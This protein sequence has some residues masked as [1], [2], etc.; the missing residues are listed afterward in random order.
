MA[1]SGRGSGVVGYNVQAA[2]DTEHDLIVAHDITNDGS[3]R[4]QLTNISGANFEKHTLCVE[5]LHSAP[6]LK[7]NK[8]LTL[9]S[10]IR[11]S[12]R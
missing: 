8:E 9:L 6:H 4:A 5:R 11:H 7:V 10:D 2:V 3:D 12:M 1:T